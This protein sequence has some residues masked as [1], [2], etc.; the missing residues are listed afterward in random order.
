MPVLAIFS[1]PAMRQDQYELLR[2]EIGWERLQPVG[3]ILHVA[4]FDAAGGTHV[5]DVWESPEALDAFVQQRLAPKMQAHQI[6]PPSVEVY[7]V[8]NLNAYG[9][10]ERFILRPATSS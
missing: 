3:G 1:A 8:H 4:S 5:V 9:A 10:I 6:A 2:R 7:P